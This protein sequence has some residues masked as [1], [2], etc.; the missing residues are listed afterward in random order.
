MIIE[1]EILANKKRLKS[2]LKQ[3]LKIYKTKLIKIKIYQNF[4]IIPLQLN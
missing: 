1:H 2:Y 3:I 4:E